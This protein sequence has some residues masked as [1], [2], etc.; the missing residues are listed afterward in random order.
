MR[1]GVIL[2]LVIAIFITSIYFFFPKE[3]IILESES[4]ITSS[5]TSPVT[6]D[7]VTVKNYVIE[8]KNGDLNW[9]YSIQRAIFK[10]SNSARNYSEFYMKASSSIISNEEPLKAGEYD[11]YLFNTHSI[12]S[13][14]NDGYGLVMTG[15][16]S[17]LFCFGKNKEALIKV[18]G[19]FIEK[20]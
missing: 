15:N 7:F 19:W 9:K 5:L 1:R 2:A 4:D 6:S 20:Y 3:T 12:E 14:N 10:D 13:G 17:V 8:Y 11:G 18:V 16:E